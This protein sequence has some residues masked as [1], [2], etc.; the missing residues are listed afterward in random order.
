MNEASRSGDYDWIDCIG[1]GGYGDVWKVRCIKP[2]HPS[3][4]KL[5]A[6]KVIRNVDALSTKSLL[7]KLENEVEVLRSLQGRR[8][9]PPGVVHLWVDF[10]DVLPDA[11]RSLYDPGLQN[12]V[13]TNEVD[14]K[15]AGKAPG[16]KAR[17]VVFDAH[18]GTLE[19][20]RQ[21]VCRDAGLGGLLPPALFVPKA[22][23]L[24]DACS[25][26][27]EAGVYHLDLKLVNILVTEEGRLCICDFGSACD[28]VRSLACFSLIVASVIC[29]RICIRSTGARWSTRT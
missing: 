24:F 1:S 14:R 26:L 20:W 7:A 12:I 11:V 16:F 9:V 6:I 3:P 4:D 2:G 18:A 25:F 28:L 15:K 5:Y 22:L 13:D 10:V 21:D 29:N 23:E 8:R 27:N 19:H 17:F